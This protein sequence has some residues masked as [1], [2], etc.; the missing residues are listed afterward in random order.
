MSRIVWPKHVG[1][2]YRCNCVRKG[3][4][5]MR[6]AYVVLCALSLSLVRRVLIL[7]N[8]F[9]QVPI[10]AGQNSSCHS[11][12][13]ATSGKAFIKTC[14]REG[15]GFWVYMSDTVARLHG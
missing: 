6:V 5:D 10:A 3:S 2:R 13:V 12:P 1:N 9:L 4:Y 7:I 11:A 15:K 8:A 14:M